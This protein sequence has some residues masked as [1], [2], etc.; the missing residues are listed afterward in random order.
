MPAPCTKLMMSAVTSN[1]TCRI[2]PQR[3]MV[4]A[5]RIRAS[6]GERA[7]SGSGTITGL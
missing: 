4:A 1:A 3:K 2:A 7:S 6:L 5:F